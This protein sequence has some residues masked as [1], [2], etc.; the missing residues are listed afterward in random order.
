MTVGR[1][2]LAVGVGGVRSPDGV[3][4]GRQEGLDVAELALASL[5]PLADEPRWLPARRGYRLPYFH[6]QMRAERRGETVHYQSR[7]IERSGPRAEFR[8]EYR[9]AGPSLPEENGSLPRWLAERYCVYVV[10]EGHRV[11]RGDIHRPWPLQ[12]ATAEF[13]VNT[14][15]RPL[16]LELA[17][18]ALLHYSVR[19]D[20]VIWSLE[21][22]NA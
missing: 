1:R 9:P 14:M 10:D 2:R 8:A 17:G 4:D 11:L 12:P 13:E 6:A 18:E 5:G 7:R 22:V 21:G 20:V 3:A 19:Q 16:G 15:A